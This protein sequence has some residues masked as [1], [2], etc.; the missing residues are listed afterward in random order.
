METIIVGIATAL[1]TLIGTLYASKKKFTTDQ[2]E[3]YANSNRDLFKELD[4]ALKE[5][6]RTNADLNEANQKRIIT[7]NERDQIKKEADNLRKTVE[8]QAVEIENLHKIVAD[9]A[10]Q[11]ADLRV[12]VENVAKQSGIPTQD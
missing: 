12:T 6:K 7:E 2:T 8:T 4:E 3:I 1:I 5:I 11:I 9:Q 10:K